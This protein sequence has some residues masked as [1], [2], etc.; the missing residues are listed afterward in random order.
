MMLKDGKA[1]YENKKPFD[2]LAEGL[3]CSK[4]LGRKDSNPRMARPKPAA[5]PLGYTP[6]I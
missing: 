3:A 2:I 1:G 6:L 4:S 5:L